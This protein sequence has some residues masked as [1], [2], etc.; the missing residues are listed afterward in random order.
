M[1]RTYLPSAEHDFDSHVG[2]VVSPEE[3]EC[4]NSN[5]VELAL[6]PTRALSLVSPPDEAEV[7]GESDAPAPPGRDSPALCIRLINQKTRR[8]QRVRSL[9][10]ENTNFKEGLNARSPRKFIN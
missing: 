1:R 7:V 8:E 4:V 2:P 3:A 10:V 6:R 9:G 5:A